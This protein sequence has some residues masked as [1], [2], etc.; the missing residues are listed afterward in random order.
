[1][2]LRAD[3]IVLTDKNNAFY[4]I[5]KSDVVWSPELTGATQMVK[6]RAF[7][8]I[9]PFELNTACPQFNS[10]VYG[11]VAFRNTHFEYR[12]NHLQYKP[13]QFGGLHGTV[14]CV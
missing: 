3:F 9:K 8:Q 7:A 12:L 14:S 2:L 4:V 1:M 11:T 5:R 13:T 6:V 10:R